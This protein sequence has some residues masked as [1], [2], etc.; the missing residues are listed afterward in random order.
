MTVTTRIRMLTANFRAA[1]ESAEDIA[2]GHGWEDGR[3]VLTVN[4]LKGWKPSVV[5]GQ[6]CSTIIRTDLSAALG[7]S[8]RWVRN[9]NVIVLWNTNHHT[10]LDSSTLM[11][12]SPPPVEGATFDPRRLVLVQLRMRATGD[13][14]WVASSHFTPGSPDW[15]ARQMTASVEAIHN[16]G[17]PRN[18][19]FGGDINAGGTD[20]ESPRM[21]GRAA[22]LFDLRS[23]LAAPRIGNVTSNT[24]N[25]WR[26]P[27][28]RDGFWIDDVL[29]GNNFQPYY[30]RVIDTNGAS[31]HQWIIASSIQL[32]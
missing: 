3:K 32:T 28:P 16:D 26:Q 9:G 30:G 21:I 17:D 1:P 27:A 6:E 14:F 7:A 12:P 11:L 29:T 20:T 23:K 8:W 15:Q 18:T 22:G 24:F 31:D 19:I 5:C 25:G 4:L 13:D 2:A 10:F